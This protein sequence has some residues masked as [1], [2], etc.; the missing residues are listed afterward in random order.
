M[1]NDAAHSLWQANID[2]EVAFWRR[3]AAGELPEKLDDW[4]ARFDPDLPIQDYALAY[5]P[6]AERAALRIL[7]VGAGPATTLGKT[8]RGKRLDL[9]AVDP[10]AE[11]YQ[12]VL[13]EFG[14]HPPSPSRKGEAERLVE[15][16][17][18]ETFDLVYSRNALDHSYDPVRAF[19]QIIALLKPGRSA[20]IECFA[21]EAEHEGY[22]GLHQ[23]NFDVRGSDFV[24]RGKRAPET[25]LR[26]IYGRTVEVDAYKFGDWIYLWL[27]RRPRGLVTRLA[28]LLKPMRRQN[29]HFLALMDETKHPGR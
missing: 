16:F 19:G 27:H 6:E 24:I 28:R 20:L 1:S 12:K 18:E 7:D 10:L 23:W 17:G 22:G 26:R 4:R 5:T 15:L 29:A 13:D 25:S 9:T 11:H 2:D 3:L 14:L 21:N 8:Y